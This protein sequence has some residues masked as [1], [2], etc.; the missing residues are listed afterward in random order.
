MGIVHQAAGGV[1]VRRLVDRARGHGEVDQI[2]VRHTQHPT[3]VSLS[4]KSKVAT[5]SARAVCDLATRLSDD[6]RLAVVAC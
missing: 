4:V 5:G 6:R 2:T 1:E 3:G